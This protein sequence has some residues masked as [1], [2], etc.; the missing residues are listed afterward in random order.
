MM[1]R[2]TVSASRAVGGLEGDGGISGDPSSGQVL[3][4]VG[5]QRSHLFSAH[6]LAPADEVA[7]IFENVDF[8]AAFGA[9]DQRAIGSAGAVQANAADAKM[10]IAHL[11]ATL[12]DDGAIVG[13]VR[14]RA[15]DGV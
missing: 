6:P 12:H 4:C 3:R 11:Q 7:A 14:M 1:A 8:D 2:N 13:V 15:D 5:A 9:G 10:A